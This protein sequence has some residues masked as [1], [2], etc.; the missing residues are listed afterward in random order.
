MWRGL[1]CLLVFPDGLVIIILQ[2]TEDCCPGMRQGV[3]LIL[4]TVNDNCVSIHS[5][6]QC[7]RVIK[8]SS[9]FR[10]VGVGV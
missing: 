9:K 6:A 5:L 4:Q 8:G 2:K 1:S 7:C 3:V 10:V